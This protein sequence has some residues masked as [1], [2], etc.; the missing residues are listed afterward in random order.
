MS[1]KP[2]VVVALAR[3]V[4]GLSTSV[5]STAMS[6]GVFAWD[7][8]LAIYNLFAPNLPA[9]E[10]VP[11]GCPGH[12]GAWPQYIAPREGDSRSACPAL[13][14]MANHGILPRDGRNITFRELT[15]RVRETYNF[16]P[17]FCVFVDN[18]A[19]NMLCRDYWTGKLDLSDISVH[20][21]IEYDGSLTRE[22][23]AFQ[24]DQGK[25][26][27]RLVEELLAS[28]TGPNGDLTPADLSRM[29]SKRRSESKRK[30]GQYSLNTIQRFF[31][32][33]NAS[34]LV[35]IFGGKMQD[36][37]TMLVEERI[38][39]GWQSRVLHPMGLTM[40][41]FNLTALHVELG[42]TEELPASFGLSDQA[43]QKKNM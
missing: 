8:G 17:S 36:I 16:S 35:T 19:A 18:Y 3:T 25:P 40:S 31:S 2:W 5:L 33:S 24:S 14:A 34:T 7:S 4:Y 28:G 22:D 38:P 10:V 12:R 43:A 26:T 21:C 1:E 9:N 23:T 6:V 41:Q 11:K 30:N 39:D 29:I 32:S 15:A 37:R 27:M 20:N 42:I 13:N